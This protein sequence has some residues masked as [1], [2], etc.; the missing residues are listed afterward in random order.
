MSAEYCINL[1]T[2]YLQ[3]NANVECFL[4]NKTSKASLTR[5]MISTAADAVYVRH[6]LRCADWMHAPNASAHNTHTH[7]HR[8]T[9]AEN[10]TRVSP[11]NGA[12]LMLF[13]LQYNIKWCGTIGSGSVERF[14]AYHILDKMNIYISHRKKN[15]IGFQNDCDLIVAYNNHNAHTHINASW[16]R[17]SCVSKGVSTCV[18]LDSQLYIKQTCDHL[19]NLPFVS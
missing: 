19:N 1:W 7:R 17:V 16:W 15:T 8:N 18:D 9:V 6:N 13:K 11:L 3:T 4:V 2:S 5:S 10:R 14:A 12:L